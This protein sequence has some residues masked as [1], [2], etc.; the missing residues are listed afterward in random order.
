MFTG[1]LGPTHGLIDNG[2]SLSDDHV[3]LAE[4]LSD[5]GY[6]TAGFFGG[7]YLHPTFGL[8]QGFDVYES[9]MTTTPDAAGDDEVRSSAGTPD[10]PSH[11][12][13]T[14]PRTREKVSS[15]AAG[16]EAAAEPYF[17]FLH[18]WDV[19]YDF[20]PPAEYAQ[21]FV[22]SNYAGPAD[23]RLMSNPEIRPG[24]KPADLAHVLGLYDAEIRFT[25]DIIRDIFDD[26]DQRGMMENTLVILTSDHG[27]EFFEHG[28]KGHNKTLFDEVLRVPLIVSWQGE[29]DDRQV[30]GDQVQ[31]TDIMPTIIGFTGGPSSLVTQGHDLAPL[32]AGR[33]MAP[34]DAL[35]GLFID[36]G[37]QR[38]LRSNERKVF[39]F[40]ELS[41]TVYF[42]LQSN[43]REDPAEVI[44]PLTEHSQDRRERGELDLNSAIRRAYDLKS[45]LKL[46]PPNSI[47][48]TDDMRS[49]LTDLGYLGTEDEDDG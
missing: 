15:W 3:T 31:I 4:L 19:H 41:P 29:I 17:L 18:L 46:R 28:F 27:E 12:D 40:N 34:R 21:L 13:I 49:A 20:T 32:L 10:G 6:H 1:L 33:E 30:V 48:L 23:G 45:T 26:L 8:G 16:R 24:M 14:G 25:D 38:A 7:P 22:D 42:D 11:H 5:A 47:E 43:P 35:S 39:R 2:K 37:D 36:G 44:S 9:C